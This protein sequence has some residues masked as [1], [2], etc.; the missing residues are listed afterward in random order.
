MGAG[1]YAMVVATILIAKVA[2]ADKRRGWLW[3]GVNLCISM[4]SGRYLGLDVFMVADAFLI[5]FSI[6]F[7]SN[8]LFPKKLQ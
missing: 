1:F 8:I 5:T 6:M 3:A 4:L 2:E 7:L